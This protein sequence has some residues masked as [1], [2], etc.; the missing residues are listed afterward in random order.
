LRDLYWFRGLDSWGLCRDGACIE[1]LE[2]AVRVEAVFFLW[3]RLCSSGGQLRC[4]LS[5]RSRQL[6]YSE[7][8]LRTLLSWS[9]CYHSRI[10]SLLDDGRIKLFHIQTRHL[11]LWFLLFLIINRGRP[12]SQLLLARPTRFHDDLALVIISRP[13]R[14]SGPTRMCHQTFF[15]YLV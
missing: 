14:T 1:R 15:T 4:V 6:S 2:L 3:G 11:P 8:R 5:L 7:H 13:D 12:L 10:W 9:L